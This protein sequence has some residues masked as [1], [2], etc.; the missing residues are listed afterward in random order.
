ML[1]S[2]IILTCLF[3][4]LTIMASKNVKSSIRTILFAAVS[5]CLLGGFFAALM[6]WTFGGEFLCWAAW[7]IGAVGCMF[8]TT[9]FADFLILTEPDYRSFN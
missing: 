9:G 7:K 1:T 2:M 3:A 8:V 5:G 6:C 4:F